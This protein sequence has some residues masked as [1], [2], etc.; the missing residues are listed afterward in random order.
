MNPQIF[1]LIH[2]GQKSV[3]KKFYIAKFKI[4]SR[5]RTIILT[6]NQHLHSY[7]T[8][9]LCCLRLISNRKGAVDKTKK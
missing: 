3:G 4:T 1:I 2:V 5:M 9:F 7:F 6:D 8:N